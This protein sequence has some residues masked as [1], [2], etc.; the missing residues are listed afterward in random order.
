M[1]AIGAENLTKTYGQLVAVDHISFEVEEGEVFGFLGA[2][3]AGKTS[4]IMMLA[5]A[6]NPTSGTANVRGYDIVRDRDKVRESIGIV[7]EELSL[8]INLTA[9]ENLDFHARLYH[10]PKVVRHERISQAL[11]LVGLK[12]RQ[13]TL[14]KYYSGGMQ[15]RLEIARAMLNA[16]RV[17]FLD[18]PTLGL[19]VQT[20]RLLW[21]YVRKLNQ[22]QGTTVLLNTHYVE[23]ADYLCHRI[24]ILERGKI[25]T[26]DSPKALKDSLGSTVL[27]IGFPRG[28]L[29]DGFASLLKGMGWVNKIHRR[30]AQLELS[31]ENKGMKIPDVVRL[32]RQQGFVI[33]SVGERKPT[34]EDV[35]LHYVGR[36]LP[37]GEH[38]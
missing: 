3:G 7:F 36:K 22:E 25:V 9:R 37:N 33:S 4:T 13:N 21:D 17:L 30:D 26:V 11:G 16:P 8:D 10:L 19:D 34:L 28:D 35:F 27:S 23:E 29:A 20:R 32:A 31:V 12:D 5:T 2:N 15:R 1:K 6:L 24:A 18:E 14:V 38:E